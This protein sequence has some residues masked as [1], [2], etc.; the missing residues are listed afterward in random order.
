MEGW[1]GGLPPAAAERVAR[2]RDSGVTGSLL[3]AP[4]HAAL[5]SAGLAP[6]GEVMGCIVLHLGRTRWSCGWVMGGTSTLSSGYGST[7]V[8]TS[9][10][11]GR[12]QDWQGFGPYVKA[13]QQEYETALHRMLLEAAALGADGVVG[14]RLTRTAVDAGAEELVAL[15]TAVRWS[16]G[17]APSGA[18]AQPG[19]RP[20]CTELTG[21][22]VATA[23]SSGWRPL[24]MAIGLCVALKHEDWQ[25]KQQ[26]QNGFLGSGN[27]EVA[28]LTQLL[29]AARAG[30]R[31]R[32]AERA[33]PLGRGAAGRQVVVSNTVLATWEQQCGQDTRDFVA[34]AAFFG[35]VLAPEPG[36]RAGADRTRPVLSIL[37]LRGTAPTPTSGE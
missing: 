15:G 8:V 33:S 13:R 27:T 2:Q 25:L 6:A 30:A 1:I 4:A 26:T 12:A 24:G 18:A 36:R 34:E 31:T 14:V 7:P 32:L 28:G 10:G 20:F 3:S 11:G 19:A 5:A 17:A 9:T 29:G 35:S 16:G 22:Q 21:E 37:P 23:V